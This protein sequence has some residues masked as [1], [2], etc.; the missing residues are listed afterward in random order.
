MGR[1]NPLF[2]I[3][4]QFSLLSKLI[5][6]CVPVVQVK[7]VSNNNL[8]SFAIVFVWGFFRIYYFMVEIILI[9][10]VSTTANVRV[11]FSRV[12]KIIL[13]EADLEVRHINT[14]ESVI[15]YIRKQH[16]HSKLPR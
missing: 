4:W 6:L 15:C 1:E 10:V 7:L 11:F 16:D 8:S 9:P 14:E 2:C 13:S 12:N 5:A 3:H